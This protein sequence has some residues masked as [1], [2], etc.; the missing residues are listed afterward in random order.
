MKEKTKKIIAGLGIGLAI[1]G[2]GL[3]TGCTDINLTQE[4]TDKILTVVDNADTFM[5]DV[6]ENNQL[7]KSK[8][9]DLLK[10][11]GVKAKLNVDGYFNNVKIVCSRHKN[12]DFYDTVEI[13]KY[14]DDHFASVNYNKDLGDN[15][16]IE[17]V[18]TK[19][20]GS[21]KLKKSVSYYTFSHTPT[22]DIDNTKPTIVENDYVSPYLC[23]YMAVF[24]FVEYYCIT[25]NDILSV[26]KNEKNNY[27]IEAIGE[28]ATAQGNTEIYI[29]VEITEDGHM[30]F[31]DAEGVHSDQTEIESINISFSVE[32]GVVDAD[33][34][35]AKIKAAEEFAASQ[36]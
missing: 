34:V 14:D 24:D 4:Q 7:N 36:A 21:E 6:M 17:Y 18:Y 11:V 26:T 15:Y 25:E 12:N 5:K 13:L 2:A 22:G 1:S 10:I 29:T 31:F 8:A 19:E 3:L 30:L 20:V 9:Y 16:N 27:V 28:I 35:K 33:A 23:G 32:Y